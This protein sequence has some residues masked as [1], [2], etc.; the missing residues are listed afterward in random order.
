MPRPMLPFQYFVQVTEIETPRFCG[1]IH[2]VHGRMEEDVAMGTSQ[3][4]DVALN[5]ARIWFEVLWVVELGRVDED[6]ANH[7]IRQFSGMGGER[8]VAVVQRAHSRHECYTSPVM[9]V[10]FKKPL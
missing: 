9:T 1:I 2:F 10:P 4:V 3:E 5:R 6:A 8:K 7:H